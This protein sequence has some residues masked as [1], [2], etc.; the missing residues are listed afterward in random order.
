MDII[1]IFKENRNEENAVYMKKYMKDKFDFLGIKS[2]KRK[3]LQKEFFKD[4]DK[5]SLIDKTLVNNLWSEN[6]REYQY[7]AIDYLIKKKKK[8]A[9]DDILFIKKLITNKSWWD[10]VDLIASHLLGEI[11]KLYP[12][13]VDEYIIDWSKDENLWIRRSAI[14]YQLKYKENV[15]TNTLER[16]IRNNKEDNDFF[17]RKAIGWMLREYSKTNKEWVKVFISKNELSKLSIKEASKYL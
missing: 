16:V 12:E 10:S 7:V 8:L 11:C 13:L 17:I 6:Y 14:L 1:D 9:K 5:K 2:S 4:I 3:E 15:D